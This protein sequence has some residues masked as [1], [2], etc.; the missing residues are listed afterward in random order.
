MP[1]ESEFKKPRGH[2]PLGKKR[3]PK[4][5]ARLKTRIRK[6]ITPIAGGAYPDDVHTVKSI[7]RAIGVSDRTLRRW[8][9]GEDNPSSD[10]VRRLEEWLEANK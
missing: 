3:N 7:A 6:R 4:M 9:A 5:P 10:H 8:L 2:W 1:T